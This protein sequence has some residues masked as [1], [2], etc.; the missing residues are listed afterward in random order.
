MDTKNERQNE[1][2]VVLTLENM[3]QLAMSASNL[4][5]EEGGEQQVKE[6][7]CKLQMVNP[8]TKQSSKSAKEPGISTKEQKGEAK[9]EGAA[10]T[11]TAA[12]NAVIAAAG[13]DGRGK[14]SKDKDANCSSD[15]DAEA[16]DEDDHKKAANSAITTA[17]KSKGGKGKVDKGKDDDCG[18]DVDT[19]DDDDSKKQGTKK[20]KQYRRRDHGFLGNTP[21]QN[22]QRLKKM[23]KLSK[24]LKKDR[25]L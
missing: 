17:G 18:S 1:R 4:K 23:W 8:L 19:K 12:A 6:E 24:F 10:K 9:E 16:E 3:H 22:D 21:W 11:A 7:T 5:Q 15:V 13:K 2:I 20:W 14:C 25:Y